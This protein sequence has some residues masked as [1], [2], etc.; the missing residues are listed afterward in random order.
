MKDRF[1]EV[2][3]EIS[4]AEKGLKSYHALNSDEK[5]L[6][7]DEVV[8]IDVGLRYWTCGVRFLEVKKFIQAAKA[9]HYAGHQLRLA[10]RI[11]Q[12]ARAYEYSGWAYAQ[13]EFDSHDATPKRLEVVD[14]QIRSLARAKASYLELGRV[15]DGDRAY[16]NEQCAHREQLAL[17]HEKAAIEGCGTNELQLIKINANRVLFWVWEKS[18]LFGT[19]KTR[20]LGSLLC[21]VIF[22]TTIY[23]LG[24]TPSLCH[25]L[26]FVTKMKFADAFLLALQTT[27]T[28]SPLNLDNPPSAWLLLSNHVC[29]YAALA[30]GVTILLRTLNTR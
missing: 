21:V 29:G 22:F 14:D 27:A 16:V 1:T 11:H 9:L 2:L 25:P 7:K 24:W 4:D 26:N 20:W 28:Q 8:Q 19:S 17:E 23:W 12:A 18:C 5:R 10:D 30:M 13:H 3:Q 15:T 6:Q